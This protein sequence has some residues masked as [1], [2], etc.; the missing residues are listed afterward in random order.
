MSKQ[1]NL[2]NQRAYPTDAIHRMPS[3]RRDPLP[4][5]HYPG[6]DEVGRLP[7]C[8]QLEAKRP[9][10]EARSSPVEIEIAPG[11]VKTLKGSQETQAAW[12]DGLCVEAICFVCESRLAVAPGCDSVICPLCRSV[13]PIFSESITTTND[14]SL[15]S[16]DDGDAVGLGISLD[17]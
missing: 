2:Y 4:S 3:F 6:L 10:A 8:R 7:S 15:N 17:L 5:G 9:V 12:D 16:F 1:S 13:S 11:V 14:D